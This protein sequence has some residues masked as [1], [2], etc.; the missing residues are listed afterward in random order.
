MELSGQ[1][2][3]TAALPLRER[4]RGTHWMGGRVDPRARLKGFIFSVSS[5]LE[6]ARYR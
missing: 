6:E 4:G 3:N 1:L 2:H 5:E